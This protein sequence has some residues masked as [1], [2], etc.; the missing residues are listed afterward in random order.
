MAAKGRIAIKYHHRPRPSFAFDKV[1]L[2][3]IAVNGRVTDN[4]FNTQVCIYNQ[5]DAACRYAE[6]VGAQGLV[7]G[8]LFAF[9]DFLILLE[10]KEERIK[11]FNLV[12]IIVAAFMAFASLVCFGV[13]E[14]MLAGMGGRQPSTGARCP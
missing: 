1:L 8:V 7:V 6:A 9:T 10:I 5:V 11:T 12:S 4:F 2:G 13:L 14:A 3:I